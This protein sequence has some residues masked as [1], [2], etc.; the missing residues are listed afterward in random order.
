MKNWFTKVEFIQNVNVIRGG[1]IRVK[2][3]NVSRFRSLF[4]GFLPVGS[5]SQFCIYY[6]YEL[7]ILI[8]FI[9]LF[10][11]PDCLYCKNFNTPLFSGFS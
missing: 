10:N 9:M 2:D 3:L 5:N 7:L 8:H 6:F 4:S 11:I 1:L